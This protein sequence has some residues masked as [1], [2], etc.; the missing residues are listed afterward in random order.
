MQQRDAEKRR[1]AGPRE[2]SLW[3]AGRSC[4]PHAFLVSASIPSP[5]PQKSSLHVLMKAGQAATSLPSCGLQMCW[6]MQGP[7]WGPSSLHPPH[8]SA[9]S[10]FCF[11]SPHQQKVGF[12]RPGASFCT[13]DL[14]CSCSP[15]RLLELL[16]KQPSRALS[17]TN[18]GTLCTSNSCSVVCMESAEHPRGI[19]TQTELLGLECFCPHARDAFRAAAWSRLV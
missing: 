1:N 4:L 2:N 18:C 8:S 17:E 5:F 3:S 10:R 15:T 14:E 11:C 7:G 9:P 13:R 19:F 16:C 12:A 6:G